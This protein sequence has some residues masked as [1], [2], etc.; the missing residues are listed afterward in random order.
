MRVTQEE[1]L[2]PTR[3]FTR[4]N[5]NALSELVAELNNSGTQSARYN[6]QR[7]LLMFDRMLCVIDEPT[8]SSV[9]H[10]GTKRF[11]ELQDLFYSALA[12]NKFNALSPSVRL[13]Y[14]RTFYT[15]FRELKE[16][17][18]IQLC[19]FVPNSNK[20]LPDELAQAFD[21]TALCQDEAGKAQPFLLKD[22]R[23]N[24]YNVLLAPMV[25]VLGRDFTTKFHT[26]LNDIARGKAKDTGL[27]D[28]GTTFAKFVAAQAEAS[29]PITEVQLQDSKFVR[30]MLVDF[31]E[32][33]F[34]KF[35]NMKGGAKEGTLASLQKTWGR[36]SIYL[37][38]LITKN[39]ITKPEFGIPKGKPSLAYVK[40]VRH[41]RKTDPNDDDS[42]VT[43]KLLTPV[44]L[45][46]SDDAT[47][48]VIFRQI[49]QDFTTVQNWLDVHLESLWQSYEHGISV[50]NSGPYRLP[51][52]E[53]L[54]DL[55]NPKKNSD[56]L[57]EAVRYFKQEHKGYVDTNQFETAAYPGKVA[58]NGVSKV[59]LAQLLGV[60]NRE[61]AMAMVAYLTSVDG[62]FT[63][64]ALADAKLLDRNGTRI[65][66]VNSGEGTI[67]LSVLKE[68]AG[69]EGWHNVVLSGRAY[70]FMQRWLSLTAPL[71]AY[72]KDNHVKG[73]QNLFIY[74]GQPLSKP[75]FFIR[76]SNMNSYFR[77]FAQRNRSTL[78]ELTEFVTVNRI[79][80]QKGILIFLK[81]FD[82]KAMA[83][84]LGNDPET[85]MR[86]YLPDAIWDY[87]AVRWI[88]IFQNLL[89]V[90]ATRGTAYMAR[91]L[92][93]KDATE[94]DEFLKNH[95]LEPLIPEA[96]NEPDLFAE[97]ELEDGQ[98]FD[99][100]STPP[101][102]EIMVAASHD[103]FSTLLSVK[104][105]VEFTLAAG[106]KVHEK[107]IYWYEFAKRL[108]VHIE[109]DAYS[110]RGI[111]KLMK[112][113]SL[114]VS[115]DNFLKAVRA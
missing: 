34:K 43:H 48:A 73:W 66:A 82:I 55:L 80:A 106:E 109:S 2:E 81:D 102:K 50:S 54:I 90:E 29:K 3:L 56:A 20:F 88:R 7:A 5:G 75:A 27:R 44:P 6:R 11:T 58:R 95:A 13:T 1:W 61:D 40:E 14:A 94:L 70:V 37:D 60:P 63:E 45:H 65:N 108:Q 113:A 98:E 74:S 64:S 100:Q 112:A 16:R 57:A 36:Y 18:S 77:A 17:F 110:D 49:N 9:L 22:K 42:G 33:H 101:V 59:K 47:T 97:Q 84:E 72:M 115:R 104:E 12:S 19:S 30:N 114:N 15:F 96:V 46:L 41:Q 32:T 76:T 26:A 68:R 39:V 21:E 71:R 62:R 111:K 67:T 53:K 23:G 83:R 92:R 28:F 8:I 69:Q 93:F 31:M 87:F 79:R 107:A 91:A 99:R 85:S 38:I 78:G 86:H 25:Q 105:A 4:I 52:G 35:L 89:I 51:E 103:I 10:F 24:T